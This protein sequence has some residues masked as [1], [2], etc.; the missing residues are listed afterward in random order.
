MEKFLDGEWL[1]QLVSPFL[2]L[3]I[4]LK[5]HLTERQISNI[6]AAGCQ[7][8]GKDLILV[9]SIIKKLTF[10][11]LGALEEKLGYLTYLLIRIKYVNVLYLEKNS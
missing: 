9:R 6:C 5:N 1:S 2:W 4:R 3:F 7:F 11:G 10:S 8:C